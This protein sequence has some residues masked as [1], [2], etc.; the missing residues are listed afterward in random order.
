MTPETEDLRP[1]RSDIQLV[2]RKS[3]VDFGTYVTYVGAIH[4]IVVWNMIYSEVGK[5]V[6]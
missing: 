2:E 3:A 1:R 5:I 6:Q 4:R